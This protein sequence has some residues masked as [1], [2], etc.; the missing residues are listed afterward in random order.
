[1]LQMAPGLTAAIGRLIS[2]KPVAGDL[3]F[4]IGALERAW[5]DAQPPRKEPET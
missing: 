2:L 1:M 3:V 5:C 4:A